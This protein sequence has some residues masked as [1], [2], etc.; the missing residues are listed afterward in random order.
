[1]ALLLL[2]KDPNSEGGGSPT[3]YYDE[4]QDTYVL[5]SWKLLDPERLAQMDIPDH[6]TAIEFP[7][8]MMQFF[9]EVSGDGLSAGA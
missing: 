3:V 8:R 5:Q 4:E 2:G 6:E 9:P 7:R 1:M